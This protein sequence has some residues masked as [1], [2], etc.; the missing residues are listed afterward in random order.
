MHLSE[1]AIGTSQYPLYF[2]GIILRRGDVA[3]A[4]ISCIQC[5]FLKGRMCLLFSQ[6]T[7]QAR[8]NC[9]E[10]EL[11]GH[12]IMWNKY[13]ANCKNIEELQKMKELVRK[14]LKNIHS[15]AIKAVV[16]KNGDNMIHKENLALRELVK[17]L[18]VRLKNYE[19]IVEG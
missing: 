8:K 10:A 18:L 3:S 5:Q 17:E 4:R 7:T 14:A 11:A 1:K 2:T 6:P 15:K 9:L 16:Y 19:K 12:F 13:V